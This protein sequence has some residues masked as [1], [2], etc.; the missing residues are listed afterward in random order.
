[1]RA[2]L[3]FWMNLHFGHPLWGSVIM[4]RYLS[5]LLIHNGMILT[6]R[7]WSDNE[8]SMP[9]NGD[10]AY[11]VLFDNSLN[12]AKKHMEGKLKEQWLFVNPDT[13]NHYQPKK[14]DEL[15]SQTTSEV[16]FHEATRHSFATKL[17]EE[18]LSLSD[19]QALGSWKN[20]QSMKPYSHVNIKN[21]KA[22]VISYR[23]H[24]ES[25]TPKV[26]DI[27]G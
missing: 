27:K 7:G 24:T 5:T 12:I 3:F 22:R 14:I 8:I 25:K 4:T 21:I 26:S 9:K 15:W 1:M 2:A 19:V 20:I 10:P 11:K 6:E 13:N 17:L 16:K 18:G 23:I